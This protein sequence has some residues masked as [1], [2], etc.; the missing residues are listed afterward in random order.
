[1]FVAELPGGTKP[2]PPFEFGFTI[3]GLLDVVQ[4]ISDEHRWIFLRI[5]SGALVEPSSV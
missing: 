5:A 4:A 3:R 2:W 1:M